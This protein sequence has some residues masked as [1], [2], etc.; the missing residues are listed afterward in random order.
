MR[1]LHKTSHF[2]LSLGIM[3][4][5]LA[6][7][8]V[9]GKV[10][11]ET[12]PEGFLANKQDSVSYALG[13]LNGESFRQSLANMPKSASI[14]RDKMMRGFRNAYDNAATLISKEDAEKLLSEFLQEDEQKHRQKARSV[15]DSLIDVHKS[16][17]GVQTT[18]SGLQY[19][20]LK[21]G[22]G[23]APTLQQTVTI[24]YRGLLASSGKEFENSYK[25]K[26]PF[27]T[28]LLAVLPAVA[29]GIMLMQPGAKY[30]FFLPYHLAYQENGVGDIP[31]YANLIMEIELLEVGEPAEMPVDKSRDDN[32]D[33]KK[34]KS[35]EE[36]EQKNQ[37]NPN[38]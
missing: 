32:K 38:T 25:R 16:M 35:L 30:Q 1:I 11:G 26:Q 4:V 10:S 3:A 27:K 17:P 29:E 18:E 36:V 33:E 24:H 23:K 7:C 19:V 14:N 20:I 15:A 28:P 5:T 13:I 12:L 22:S 34:E 31:P 37:S 9:L 21:K 8:S 6:S 2:F